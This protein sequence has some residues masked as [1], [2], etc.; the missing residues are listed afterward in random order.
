MT[1]EYESVRSRILSS[2]QSSRRSSLADLTPLTPIDPPSAP[3]PPTTSLPTCGTNL[4]TIQPCF[5]PNLAHYVKKLSEFRIS[6]GFVHLR[7]SPIHRFGYLS[8]PHQQYQHL[9]DLLRRIDV[10]LFNLSS[11]RLETFLA[12]QLTRVVYGSTALSRTGTS[13][14]TTSR[15]CHAIFACAGI[16][17]LNLPNTPGYRAEL[18]AVTAQGRRPDIS[19]VLGARQAV[20]HQT[21]A[22]VYFVQKLVC[23][24]GELT[25]ELIRDT[26]HIL[27]RDHEPVDD[28]PWQNFGGWYRDYRIVRRTDN[29]TADADTETLSVTSASTAGDRRTGHNYSARNDDFDDGRKQT[30]LPLSSQ[31]R[32][33]IDPRIVEKYMAELL[34]TYNM[35]LALYRSQFDKRE[36]TQSDPL[37]LIAWLCSE[38]MHIRP[39]LTANEEISRIILTGVLLK[40]LGIVAVLGDGGDAARRE[41]TGILERGE[42]R[43]VVDGKDEAEEDEGAS[44]AEFAGLIVRKTER[45]IEEFAAMVGA[46]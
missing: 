23:D 9:T 37:A 32:S 14:A 1:S 7:P 18:D 10:N 12:A 25:Q 24:G 42:Q 8:E 45:G 33:P 40:E 13:H 16:T 39:F 6:Q 17:E 27:V 5:V 35:Q 22:L 31:Q 30:R 4:P 15:I 29:G 21:H 41:Y 26:H 34:S 19:S 20:V 2:G 46:S 36:V 11:F 28:I 38:F 3:Q 44:Y 43:H